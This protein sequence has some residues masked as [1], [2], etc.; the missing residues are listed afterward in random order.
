MLLMTSAIPKN[1]SLSMK[2]LH[3]KEGGKEK[4]GKR[5][6]AFSQP[7]VPCTL[8]PVTRVSFAF[9]PCLHAKNEALRRRQVNDPPLPL[10]DSSWKILPGGGGVFKGFERGK[11]LFLSQWLVVVYKLNFSQ[12]CENCVMI[13]RQGKG[14]WGPAG[15][16]PMSPVWI[17]KHLV[18]VFIN[19]CRLLSALPS[20]LQFGW[21]RLSLVAIS[22]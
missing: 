5:C 10:M 7:M 20:L 15:G 14:L 11:L 6:F 17:L 21:G 3:A 19:A 18:L 12:S 22:F 9:R 4:T 2:H 1:L 13:M 8:S 16:G